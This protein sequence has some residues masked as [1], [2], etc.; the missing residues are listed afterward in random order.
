MSRASTIRRGL[1]V[2]LRLERVERVGPELVEKGTERAQ[3]VG[4]HGIDPPRADGF[5]LHETGILEDAQ[6]LRD[7]R[8]ADRERPRQLADG[9]RPAA[10][11]HEDGAARA[12]P[13]GVQLDMFVS[14]H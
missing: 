1:R 4:V 8:P 11:T 2:G 9:H 6:V 12:V 13:Q 10:Q 3:P 5:V 7:R 14:I